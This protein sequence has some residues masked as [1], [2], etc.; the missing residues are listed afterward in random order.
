MYTELEVGKDIE[1]TDEVERLYRGEEVTRPEQLLPHTYYLLN[2]TNS[3]HKILV[4]T[5]GKIAK[6]ISFNIAAFDMKPKKNDFN[7]LV[8]M[9]A[10]LDP[11]IEL[12]TVM[13]KAGSGKTAL[14]LACALDLVVKEKYDNLIIFKSAQSDK[15]EEIGFL[16][17]DKDEKLSQSFY[18]IE[19]FLIKHLTKVQYELMKKSEMIQFQPMSQILGWDLDNSLVILDEAQML[20]VD[21]IHQVLTR[22]G[23][24]SKLILTGDPKQQVNKEMIN[25]SGLEYVFNNWQEPWHARVKLTSSY[26]SKI[27]AKASEYE[28]DAFSGDASFRWKAKF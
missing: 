6:P 2:N 17:G 3:R 24:K 13:G 15:I 16:P 4:K 21:K 25:N 22:V 5:N 10:L 14:A 7:Q 20:D 8:Y 12:V 23:A 19:R 18:Q 26:R 1:Y 9:D 28:P 11:E 27:A